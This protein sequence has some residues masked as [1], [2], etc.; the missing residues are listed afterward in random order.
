M[1]QNYI[2]AMLIFLGVLG[3]VWSQTCTVENIDETVY[4]GAWG[5]SV[6]TATHEKL[7]QKLGLDDRGFFDRFSFVESKYGNVI[8]DYYN[9]IQQLWPLQEQYFDQTKTGS[10]QSLHSEIASQFNI[11]WSNVN[12]E[13][14]NVPLNSGIAFYLY[15]ELVGA[16]PIPWDDQGQSELYNN[17]TDQPS[18]QW[19]SSIDILSDLH[20]EMCQNQEIDLVFLADESGSISDP[21]FYLMTAFIADIISDLNVGANTTRACI[22]TFSYNTRSQYAL[23]QYND[24]LVAM[25]NSVKS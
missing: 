16:F 18:L 1:H 9:N 25:T 2:R 10:L 17:I 7:V 20:E 13:E 22:R 5:E 12:Y 15:M 8:H 11:Q 3:L 14:L 23:S 6:A 21:D 24:D 19:E 4:P